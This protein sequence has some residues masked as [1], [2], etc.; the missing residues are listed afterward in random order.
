MY[1]AKGL[2]TSK[3]LHHFSDASEYGY[4]T[5]SYLKLES[6]SKEVNIAFMV[7]KSRVAPVKQT[8]IH[9]LELTAAQQC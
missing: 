4:G 6:I 2:W 3:Q 9:R 1:Q 5:I 7:G 8:T